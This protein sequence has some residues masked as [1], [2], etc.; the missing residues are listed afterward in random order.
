MARSHPQDCISETLITGWV[1]LPKGWLGMQ[2]RRGE[3]DPPPGFM[4]HPNHVV[5]ENLVYFFIAPYFNI[6]D[7]R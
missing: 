5:L 6:L 4:H 3:A 2:A 7:E 1:F